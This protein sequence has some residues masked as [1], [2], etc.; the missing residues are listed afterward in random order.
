MPT[1]R[2]G[3]QGFGTAALSPAVTGRRRYDGSRESRETPML[4]HWMVL[5]MWNEVRCGSLGTDADASRF[6]PS[7]ERASVSTF[8]LASSKYIASSQ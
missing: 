5:T 4:A 1:P 2:R 8:T 3:E 6:P 7:A